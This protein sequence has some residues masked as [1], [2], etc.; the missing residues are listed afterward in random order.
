MLQRI[1][2]V[3]QVAGRRCYNVSGT[4]CKLLDDDVTTY[5]ERL[6]RYW[7][8]MLQ[9]IKN[10]LQV[11]GRRCYNVSGTSCKLLDE[12]ATTYQERLTSYWTKMLQVSGT[13]CKL[14]GEDVTTYQERLASYWTKMLQRIRNVLQVTGRRCYNVSGTSCKL[15]DDDVTTY[16]EIV[17]ENA[18][19]RT[20]LHPP[21]TPQKKKTMYKSDNSPAPRGALSPKSSICKSFCV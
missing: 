20:L 13:S 4:Y 10:V 5:Q 19:H 8:M 14:L 1:R 17:I 2:N 15:L 9:R 6:A 16:Q 3:L 7:T 18:D 12:D 21:K 11:S